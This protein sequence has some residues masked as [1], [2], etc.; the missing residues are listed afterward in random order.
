MTQLYGNSRPR[1]TATVL[2][3][4]RSVPAIV[5]WVLALVVLYLAL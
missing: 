2:D 4:L 3:W 5:W 1:E